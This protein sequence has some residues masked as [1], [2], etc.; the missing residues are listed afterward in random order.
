MAIISYRTFL[1][2][3]VLEKTAVT[4]NVCSQISGATYKYFSCGTSHTYVAFQR[5]SVLLNIS[6]QLVEQINIVTEG[7]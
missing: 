7:K 3:G 6:D 4:E 2:S 1:I 5:W